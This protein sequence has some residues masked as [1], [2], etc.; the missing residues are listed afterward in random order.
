MSLLPVYVARDRVE[1]SLHVEGVR[2]AC[3]RR[4]AHESQSLHRALQHVGG[5][6]FAESEKVDQ[7][8]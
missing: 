6:M 5:K 3:N 8:G 2:V 4:G 7:R 1:V